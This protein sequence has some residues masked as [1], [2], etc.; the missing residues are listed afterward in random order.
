MSK[1][2]V[3]V[4]LL[5]GI[6]R[7]NWINPDLALLL[8]NMGRDSRFDV[9]VAAIKDATPHEVARNRTIQRDHN[10][11][12]LV[13]FDNDNYMPAGTPLDVIASAGDQ[14]SVIGLTYGVKARESEYFLFP[15][16]RMR[17]K[18]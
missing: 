1:P 11:D 15:P 14:Q 16:P 2:K 10:F 9:V 8:F 4:C 17:R 12:W 13:S 18:N 6:E 7:Q 5:T 3:L